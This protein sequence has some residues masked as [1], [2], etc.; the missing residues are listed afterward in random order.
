MADLDLLKRRIDEARAGGVDVTM[1]VDEAE[2]YHWW[3]WHLYHER[4]RWQARYLDRR[5][6]RLVRWLRAP[7]RLRDR[8]LGAP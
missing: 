2:G 3:L 7:C 4:K 1:P 6:A 5:W 8:L